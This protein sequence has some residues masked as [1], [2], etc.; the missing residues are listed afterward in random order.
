MPLEIKAV[1]ATTSIEDD[2]EFVNWNP[3]DTNGVPYF[4]PV[5]AWGKIQIDEAT[6]QPKEADLDK[7]VRELNALHK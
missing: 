2:D 7:V 4:D 5:I 3:L 6:G 1:K